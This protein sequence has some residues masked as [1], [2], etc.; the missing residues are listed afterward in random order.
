MNFRYGK[1][2][3]ESECVSTPWFRAVFYWKDC[4]NII[5]IICY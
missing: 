3:L 4:Q 5:S 1:I 2:R